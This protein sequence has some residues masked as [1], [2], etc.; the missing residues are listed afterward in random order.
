MNTRYSTLSWANL[1]QFHALVF[2]R[3]IWILSFH[4][5][6]GLLSSC[7]Q[8]EILQAFLLFISA[9]RPV[10]NWAEEGTKQEYT[11][12]LYRSTAITR[13]AEINISIQSHAM[14]VETKRH[15]FPF[16]DKGD[17]VLQLKYFAFTTIRK[18]TL[19]QSGNNPRTFG[20]NEQTTGEVYHL[21]TSR[22]G[23]VERRGRDQRVF[24]GWKDTEVY[25]Q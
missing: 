12:G 1:I 17:Q 8:T 3:S 5:R 15:V 14:V 24:T 18:I 2:S 23:T 10:Q 16:R 9:A 25:R 13:R 7:F 4:L 11:P 20:R 21:N 19:C 22:R 6:L